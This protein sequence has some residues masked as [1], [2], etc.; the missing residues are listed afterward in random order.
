MAR[1]RE[2]RMCDPGGRDSRVGTPGQRL[3]SDGSG[4]FGGTEPWI[5]GPLKGS[6]E[7]PQCQVRVRPSGAS[8]A[9]LRIQTVSSTGQG[10]PRGV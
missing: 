8:N 3:G 2:G 10:S 7:R 6:W 1:E 9:R 5:G 4:M